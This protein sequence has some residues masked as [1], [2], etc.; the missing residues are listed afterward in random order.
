MKKSQK[1]QE[2]LINIGSE[3]AKTDK[4]VN[5]WQTWF[6]RQ[7]DQYEKSEITD[8]V[9]AAILER[10]KNFLEKKTGE[11]I[12]DRDL[13]YSSEITSKAKVEEQEK[14]EQTIT[15]HDKIAESR[16]MQPPFEEKEIGRIESKGIAESHCNNCGN[17]LASSSMKFCN[18]CGS[19]VPSHPIESKSKPSGVIQE[20]TPLI[21]KTYSLSVPKPQ[22]QEP[23]ELQFE[24]TSRRSIREMHL[25]WSD[26]ISFSRLTLIGLGFFILVLVSIVL[27][28]AAERA[29][30]GL[31]VLAFLFLLFGFILDVLRWRQYSDWS[32][33]GAI[34]SYIGVVLI[35]GPLLVYVFLEQID[36]F[37]TVLIDGVGI[38]LVIIGVSLRWTDYDTKLIDLG[39]MFIEYAR[40]YQYREALKT[41]LGFGKNLV[42]G[43]FRSIG[44]GIRNFRSRFRD[45]LRIARK[46]LGKFFHTTVFG[47][48][49][50]IERL[51]KTL[52]KNLHFLGLFAAF[53]YIYL[54]EIDQ[55]NN[56]INIELLIIM[57]FFFSLGVLVTQTEKASQVLHKSQSSMLRGVISAYS[58]LSGTKIRIH[59]SKFCS[60]CLRGVHEIEFEELRQVEQ[61]DIP[62]CPYCGHR[63]WIVGSTGS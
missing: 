50:S 11:E 9:F 3:L 23:A 25:E 54:M 55:S 51:S 47:L 16:G 58:M 62:D 31:I 4:E 37:T 59:E 33:L 10:Y 20:K 21:A 46:S 43:F 41:L 36:L 52:W 8:A 34:I 48:L 57:G 12:G 38:V 53:G 42:I 63:N 2:A 6:I 24:K 28:I 40:N 27:K 39:I 5:E 26:I 13:E 7:K 14:P 18:N 32:A 44:S 1:L 29:A 60:R 17:K 35:F 61:K 45:F 22:I 49:G 56:F 30:I 15:L 19:S